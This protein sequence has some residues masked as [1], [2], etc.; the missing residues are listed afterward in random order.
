MTLIP[1]FGQ[2]QSD[3]L[4]LNLGPF[5]Q[6]LDER[7]PFFTEGTD[8]FSKADLFY[9]RRI[10]GRPLNYYDVED[11]LSDGETTNSNPPEHELLN[12]Y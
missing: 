1:D 10:G 5:E 7:R 9:S 11:N 12:L 2:V 3:N 6:R 4:V 8:L